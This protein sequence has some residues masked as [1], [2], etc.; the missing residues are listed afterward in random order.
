MN[1][2]IGFL[3]A[4]LIAIAAAPAVATAQCDQAEQGSV[5][6]FLFDYNSPDITPS[7]LIKFLDVL[8]FKLNNGIRE[9]LKSRGLLGKTKFFVR[10]CSGYPV[11]EPDAAVRNGKK[12][13]SSGVM[14]GYIDQSS[15]QLRS[16]T[17][18]TSIS[19]KPIT[20]LSNITY[21]KSSGDRVDE[22][23]VAF[24]AY[25]VGKI[26]A[27]RR[28]FVLARK[29]LLFARELKRLPELLAKD[30]SETLAMVDQ[31]SIA[32]KLTPVGR[33]SK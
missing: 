16:S 6:I 26:H 5:T 17:R 31:G 32:A 8:T 3:L 12:M 11:S 25:I 20:D 24:A 7:E 21:G 13:N 1:K 14:W 10:W 22:S 19:D 30:L 28:D 9:E 33:A 27:Q 18:L 23:Y 4:C 2:I 15:G 29:C